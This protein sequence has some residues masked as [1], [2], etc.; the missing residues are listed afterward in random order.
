MHK[1]FF[2]ILLVLVLPATAFAQL[3][4]GPTAYYNFPLLTEGGEVDV[5]ELRGVDIA[6]FTFG[7]DARLKLAIFQ[8]SGLTLFT[9]GFVDEANLLFLPP[10]IDLF[11]DAGLAFDIFFLRLGLGIGPNFSFFLG[12]SELISE[13]VSFGTNLRA[14][15]DVVLG[16]I[17]VGLSYLMQFDFDL[18]DVDPGTILD[19]DK[20]QGL[21]GLAFLFQL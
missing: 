3:Q 11:L 17:S 13:P 16:G 10:S 14:T 19:A 20:T 7:A 21:F 9:P 18:A 4:I 5:P 1:K 6:D 2:I 15:V 8:I 12:E